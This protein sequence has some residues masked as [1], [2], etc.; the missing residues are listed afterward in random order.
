MGINFE[1]IQRR[2]KERL[3]NIIERDESTTLKI[4]RVLLWQREKRASE[5][6]NLLRYNFCNLANVVSQR[7]ESAQRGVEFMRDMIDRN[8]Q[9]QQKEST[10]QTKID[11]I[12]SGPSGVG[13]NEF[14]RV[15]HPLL[16]MAARMALT[17]KEGKV[18]INVS[19][20]NIDPAFAK[21]VVDEAEMRAALD[22]M[23]E[24]EAKRYAASKRMNELLRDM[25]YCPKEIKELEA[26]NDAENHNTLSM[27]EKTRKDF[28]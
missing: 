7:A 1:E 22:S 6:N 14:L 24:A 2:E 11:L 27:V 19:T 18:Q 15:I 25:G 8:N 17:P 21:P 10:M 16:E 13:K 4:Q 20:T 28:L 9:R 26:M 23:E 3:K 5:L 12:V